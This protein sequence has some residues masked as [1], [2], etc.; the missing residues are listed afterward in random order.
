MTIC[1]LD[2]FHLFLVIRKLWSRRCGSIGHFHIWV[3]GYALMEFLC[4]CFS[5]CSPLPWSISEHFTLVIGSSIFFWMTP[6]CF[7]WPLD[8][9]SAFK[10]PLRSVTVFGK[11]PSLEQRGFV[12]FA[13]PKVW[14]RGA[15]LATT[16]FP[17]HLCFLW[18]KQC[19]S[20]LLGFW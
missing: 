20:G 5:A 9:L 19:Y 3:R 8:Y 12:C 7:K 10:D 13:L 14:T 15:R 6:V 11:Q 18:R 1:L 17:C 16:A 4:S 2:G